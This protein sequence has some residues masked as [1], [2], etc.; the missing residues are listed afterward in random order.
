MVECFS[1]VWLQLPMVQRELE[2]YL[3]EINPSD[4][5]YKCLFKAKISNQDTS[6]DLNDGLK[7]NNA[8]ITLA[9]KCVP[10]GDK[11][12]ADELNNCSDF[13]NHEINN[14]KI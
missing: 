5:L 6:I 3:L 12:N 10:P 11:P 13:F 2:G 4:F 1:L 8:F 7:L 9:L 14:L